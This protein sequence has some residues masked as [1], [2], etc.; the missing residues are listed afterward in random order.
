MNPRRS[1]GLIGILAIAE[2]RE[3]KKGEAAWR[4]E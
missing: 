3:A 2:E 1:P 4:N